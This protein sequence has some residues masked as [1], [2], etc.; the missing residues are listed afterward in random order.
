MAR[1]VVYWDGPGRPTRRELAA[2]H[3]AWRRGEL[4]TGDHVCRARAE[5]VRA[6]SNPVSP[7]EAS[8]QDFHWGRPPRRRRTFRVE[9]PAEVFELGK[10]RAVEYQTRKG[11]QDAIWVHQFGWPWPVLTGTVDG[12]LGPILGGNA[13]VTTRGI[14]G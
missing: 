7:A 8:Y 2:I 1:P 4:R 3:R 11:N 12:R 5:R 14:V 10:L 6:R 9:T 13:R